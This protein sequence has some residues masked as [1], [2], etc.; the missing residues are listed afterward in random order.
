[1]PRTRTTKKQS[2][3]HSRQN[4]RQIADIASNLTEFFLTLSSMQ[5]MMTDGYFLVNQRKNA[6][7][8]MIQHF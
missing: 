6:G 3:Q 4:A 7:T 8:P 2:L 5:S 1:M